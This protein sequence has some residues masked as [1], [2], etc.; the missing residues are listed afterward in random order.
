MSS[1]ALRDRL[2]P[3]VLAAG[4]AA[5]QVGCGGR[6]VDD[7]APRL[8]DQQPRLAPV[9]SAQPDT[10]VFPIPPLGIIKLADPLPLPPRR[11]VRLCAGGDVMLGTNLDTSWAGRAAA[12]LGRSVPALP[13]PDRLLESLKPLVRDAD[14]VLLNIEGAI[15]EGSAPPKCRP[16]SRS[17]YAFRQPVR[18]AGALRGV[19][20]RSSVVGNVANNHA[21]DAGEQGLAATVDHLE[22]A[23]VGVTGNDTLATVV[24]TELGDT[25]AILGF[26]TAQAGPDP[27]DLTAV[28]RHVARARAR[29]RRVV[30]TAHMGAEGA[31]AQRTSDETE[32]Y[33]GEDRGNPVAFAHA[34]VDAGASAVIGHG[35]HVMRAAEWRGEALILYSLGNLLT[36]GP[37]N[38][39]EPLNRGAIACVDLAPDGGVSSAVVRSTVQ[40]RPG[41]A[42]ADPTGRAAWLVDSLSALDFP[43]TGARLLGEA[44]T[45][46]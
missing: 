42:R 30:V 5:I 6:Q 37:F 43:E 16:G 45:I 7:A 3:L 31:G 25:V 19:S 14:V 33:L 22:T 24:V 36:Y 46:R 12:R 18:T 21:L 1:P 44:A 11:N 34:A 15:G 13:D 28:A 32:L 17:C 27:R 23:D 8:E 40:S 10:P 29:Y 39:A 26:S 35:P 41:V 38:L 9:D 2:A 4:L 20:Y